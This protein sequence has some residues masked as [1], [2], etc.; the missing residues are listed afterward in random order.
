MLLLVSF[1]L[2]GAVFAFVAAAQG[3]ADNDK[4]PLQKI[5]FIHYKK[6]FAKPEAPGKS[7]PVN[8]YGFL[9]A[10]AKWKT[11]EPYLINPT[12][13]D[14]LSASFVES[15]VNA[16][17]AEW[18]KYVTFNIFGDESK[19][20][21][22]QFI[23]DYTDGKNTVTFGTYSNSGVIAIANVWGYFGGKTQ[24]RELT[25]WD[26]LFNDAYFTFGDATVNTG[27]MDLQNIA[28][29]ELGHAAGMD[30]LYNTVCYQ[31]TMYGYSNEGE[32]SKRNLYNGDI[33][34]IRN[35]YGS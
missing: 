28:T 12:N 18:E 25:E 4:G 27:L 19:D 15:A 30:D 9:A 20:Y 21:S 34:G 8:C 7:K 3:S 5:T 35:L 13:Y 32:T 1:C 17:V 31:E 23:D 14:G 33:T 29:H 22:A 2:V 24:Y 10:G 6:G 16:G 11:T 26:I